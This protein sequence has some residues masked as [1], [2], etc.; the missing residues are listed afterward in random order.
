MVDFT[1]EKK[2]KEYAKSK[3]YGIK[4]SYLDSLCFYTV[5]YEYIPGR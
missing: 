4:R 1:S 3:A 2:L 5:S